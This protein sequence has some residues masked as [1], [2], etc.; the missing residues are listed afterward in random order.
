MLVTSF[1]ECS[2]PMRLPALSFHESLG[3]PLHF[4]LESV[5]SSVN[6]L[7]LLGEIAQ[8]ARSS[9]GGAAPCC[10]AAPFSS[11]PCSHYA[12]SVRYAGLGLSHD[13]VLS[14]SVNQRA[15][16]SHTPQGLTFFTRCIQLRGCEV[17]S[18]FGFGSGN[19]I[20][21]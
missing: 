14:M 20:G 18:G 16:D 15:T 13:I 2:E 8:G 6:S 7:N 17:K 3:N 21:G 11:S 12:F 5:D 9:C 4:G 10:L 1:L 19:A